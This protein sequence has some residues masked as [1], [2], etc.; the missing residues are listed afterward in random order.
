MKYYTA[1]ADDLKPKIS[2]MQTK[3]K[4]IALAKLTIF[5]HDSLRNP[6]FPKIKRTYNRLKKKKM[7]TGE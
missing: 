6:S 2:L 7:W 1:Q 3:S 4:I 5:M